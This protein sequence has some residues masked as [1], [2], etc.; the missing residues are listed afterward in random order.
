M[1]PLLDLLLVLKRDDVL[2]L[3]SFGPGEGQTLVRRLEIVRHVALPADETSH[4][5]P[6]RRCVYVIVLHPLRGLQCAYSFDEPRARY[7]KLHGL[8]IVAVDACHRM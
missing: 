8:G 1:L 4:L 5:L 6:S 2:D 3:Q 7:S